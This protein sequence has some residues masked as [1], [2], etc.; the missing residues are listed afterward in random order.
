MI[1]KVGMIVLLAHDIDQAV[2]FYEK[3]G[4]KKKFHLKDQWGEMELA[5]VIIGLCPTSTVQDRYTGVVFEVSDMHALYKKMQE[6]G[7]VCDAPIEKPHGFILTCKDPSGNFIDFYQPTPEKLKD[8]VKGVVKED[9]SCCSKSDTC[10][11][12]DA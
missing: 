4:L 11:N 6:V 10:C 9:D 5:G 3:L 1:E 12:S 2:D 8:F 7:I